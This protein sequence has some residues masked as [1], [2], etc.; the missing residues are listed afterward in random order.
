MLLVKDGIISRNSRKVNRRNK[1]ALYI[2]WK[3]GT[4]TILHVG[5]GFDAF[6]GLSERVDTV[7]ADGHE[8][9]LAYSI[10]GLPTTNN[11]VVVFPNPWAALILLNWK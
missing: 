7:Q 3:D 5:Y 2:E 10:T 6:I 9:E 4:E 11:R 1:M 8:L